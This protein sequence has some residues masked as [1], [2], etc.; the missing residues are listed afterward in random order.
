MLYAS[1]ILL[2]IENRF[3]LVDI[4]FRGFKIWWMSRYKVYE[5]I[6][7]ALKRSSG[8][9]LGGHANSN[10]KYLK[11]ISF[12]KNYKNHDILCVSGVTLRREMIDNKKFDIIFDYIGKYD[13]ENSYGILNTL[14]GNGYIKNSYTCN[15]YNMANITF[16]SVFYKKIWKIILNKNEKEYIGSLFS[17]IQEYLLTKYN[18]EVNLWEL[19]ASQTSMLIGLY[20]EARRIIKKINPK[21][22]YVECAYSPTHLLFIYAAKELSIPVVEYQHGLISEL[23]PGYKY[24]KKLDEKD[25]VPDYICVY[26][27]HF[28]KMIEAMNPKSDLKI[29]EYGYPFLYE[30]VIKKDNKDNI[31]EKFKY[32][33]TTQGELY[34]KYWVSFI[35]ELLALDKE[36]KILLKVH[37]NEIM[38]YNQLYSEIVK[39]DRLILAEGMNL[40]DCLEVAEN[41]LSCFSTCHYEALAYDVPTYVIKFPGWEHVKDLAQYKVEYFSSAKEFAQYK[42]AN[43]VNQILFNKFKKDFFNID[44]EGINQEI[45]KKIIIE[46]NKLF[47]KN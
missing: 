16:K 24:N 40:Y 41:H 47:T 42:A 36:C 1:D 22:L 19:V 39:E 13:N 27:A 45:L 17:K 29:I 18:L 7:S 26:G 4:D 5:S 10:F 30:K 12:K 23:H 34:S 21:A 15:S 32:L 25:P 43:E 46:T 11:S 38:N 31:E 37:P 9:A 44:K 8:K 3:K 14:S 20:K 28:K 6:D 35:K 33:I 2:D